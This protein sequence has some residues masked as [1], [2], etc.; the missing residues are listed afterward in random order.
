M[1]AHNA[2]AFASVTAIALGTVLAASP[3]AAQTKLGDITQLVSLLASAAKPLTL[4]KEKDLRGVLECMKGKRKGGLGTLLQD[5]FKNA[6]SIVRHAGRDL[7]EA[8]KAELPALL[9]ED[10]GQSGG[11]D[12][13]KLMDK[14]VRRFPLKCFKP[15]LNKFYKEARPH[16]LKLA[17]LLRT[18]VRAI[19]TE[20]VEPKLTELIRKGIVQTVSAI[21]GDQAESVIGAGVAKHLLDLKRFEGSA[22]T[23]GA[24]AK[25]LKAGAPLDAPLA[26]A[27]KALEPKPID[28]TRLLVEVTLELVRLKGKEW[29]DRGCPDLGVK[30][31]K[32]DFNWKEPGSSFN[33]MVVGT[34]ESKIPGGA[35]LIDLA[36][37]LVES[38]IDKVHVLAD[39]VC[40]LIPYGGAAVCTAAMWVVQF[41]AKYAV[42][43]VAKGAALDLGK[44]LVD[45]GVHLAG[46]AIFK[47]FGKVLD[48]GNRG[49]DAAIKK[50][51]VLGKYLEKQIDR[52]MRDFMDEKTAKLLEV[53]DL[54]NANALK[55]VEAAKAMKEGPAA[56]QGP[57]APAQEAPAEGAQSPP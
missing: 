52:I 34:I 24:F 56:A 32:Q 54:Y 1:R 57:E 40:A 9:G 39:S 41:A 19:W 28:K 31:S 45:V 25:A 29:V 16:L 22:R 13:G 5:F 46:K 43:V 2:F 12:L 23:V 51:G 33:R 36:L 55:L 38:M 26:A 8:A 53:I 11:A 18:Q 30:P 49:L 21:A 48:Q 37:K 15:F 27:A 4:F 6:S 3:A 35:C 10:A 44:V 20:K 14:A 42:L 47:R 7:I 50:A 17:E